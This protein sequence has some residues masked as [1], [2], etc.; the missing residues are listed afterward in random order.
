M[1]G[2]LSLIIALLLGWLFALGARSQDAAAFTYSHLGQAEG[3]CSSRIYSVCQTED[4][5]LWWANRKDVERYNGRSLRHYRLPAAAP[6]YSNYAGRS[7]KLRVGLTDSLLY[8][9]DNGGRIAV[10]DEV[11]DCLNLVADVGAMVEGDVL[12]NDVL[13]TSDGMWLAM[14]N[15]FYLLQQ[16]RLT[17]V[18]TGVFG[19]AIV[20]AGEWLLLCSREGV[21]GYPSRPPRGG[22]GPD[23]TRSAR[24]G[25]G[26][27]ML[28]RQNMECGYYD[29]A[30]RQV[31]LG[32][33][34]QGVTVATLTAD[35]GLTVE[36]RIGTALT[37]P[38]RSISPYGHQT[39]LVGIDGLGVWQVSIGQATM[40]PLFDAN[41]GEHG[42]LHG[43]GIYAV[44]SD[45][46]DNIVVGS[47]SGG[48][49]IARPV[50]STPA[51][52]QHMRGNR[53]S[54]LN[55][56]VNSV[57][58]FADGTLVMGTDN[59]ISLHNP[60]TQ[61]WTH[62]CQG[63][64]VLCLCTTPQGTMLA[65]TYGNGVYEI[66]P[67]GEARLLYT[68]QGGVLRDDHVYK[69]L[70]DRDGSLWMGCL[71][72]DLVQQS[73]S[74][75][76]YYPIHNVLDITQLPDGQMAIAT[77]DGIRLIDP[78]T[79]RQGELNYSEG[80]TDVNRYVTTLYLEGDSLLWIG[81]DGGGAYV[82]HLSDGR[83]RQITEDN[84]L[85]SNMVCSIT[86]DN[87]DRMLVATEDGL[88]FANRQEPEKMY[89]VNYCYGIQREYSDRAVTAIGHRILFGTT[90]GALVID[91][92][93]IQEINYTA[94]LRL[95]RVSCAADD[96]PMFRQRTH[97][98]LAERRLYLHYSQRTFDLCFES[99][100]LRNQFDIVYMY[101][102]SGGEWSQPST[103]Q[104]I[105]FTNMEAGTHRL[106][107][108][109][110][111]R[112]C[113]VVLDEVELTIVVA[114]PWWNSWWMWVVY[115]GL[116][117]LA[118][119]GAWQVY[120]LHT[121]YMRLV[122]TT[123]TENSTLDVATARTQ[124]LKTERCDNSQ[125]GGGADKSNHTSQFSP[126]SSQLNSD[127]TEGEEFIA[128]V[129]K[130]VADNLSDTAFNID[131]LCREMAMSRTLFYIRLK[132]Y[133]GKSPQD[134]IR[135]I[136]L[137][138]A[139]ALLRSGRSVADTAT[140]AG[141][142]NPKYFSTVFKKYFGVSP[143]KY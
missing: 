68:E 128:Q 88:A 20:P 131:R 16:G 139:A 114:Q 57:A 26:P 92:D 93:N 116:V 3:L 41:E 9:F 32:G 33:F 42:V 34:R 113:G 76:N 40:S 14:R 99:V 38:V 60:Q 17:A 36:G 11:H 126:L 80:L 101:Q 29:A 31:W 130:L 112:T 132:T 56:R 85:P 133:T 74:G 125:D 15:G 81:T 39:M 78:R 77:V 59:G 138:R 102:V 120:Q 37:N 118:F 61:Q 4:G 75:I 53:Q 35:G 64:V 111:S 134:F 2:K 104:T 137:E 62:V 103:E 87:R 115:V 30:T 1:N 8:A 27:V 28:L 121:K 51:V 79:G 44:M 73:S 72:G 12:L 105:R 71:D 50:G 98:M 122:L 83:S 140:L 25:E 52:F 96:S 58:Q 10:Y 129:T 67:A 18:A 100:N 117:L 43:N 106:L 119:Y 45:A 94:R 91:P 95:L 46:W 70:Y 5:A 21:M 7:V 48:I 19:N 82:Y 90:T 89:C 63:T 141:F 123:L 136:R 108:R 86:K 23:G 143:S 142:D 22:G 107:L 65:S 97:D 49:D 135:I 84:G 24:S 110:M 69:L 55:D 66:T 124:E 47:Y 54:L 6:V 127:D 13:P 109:C